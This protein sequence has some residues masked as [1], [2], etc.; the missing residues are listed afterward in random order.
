MDLSE[1]LA[2]L[3]IVETQATQAVAAA[4]A[5]QSKLVGIG[6]IQTGDGELINGSIAVV[7]GPGKLNSNSHII[8][9]MRDP[10][11]GGGGLAGVVGLAVPSSGRNFATGAFLVEAVDSGGFAVGTAQCSF[12]YIVVTTN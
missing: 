2:R 12:D 11:A 5:A 3:Q 10:L 6:T 1:I 7:L 8:A 9:T 4:A